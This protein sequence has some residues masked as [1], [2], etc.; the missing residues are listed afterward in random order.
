MSRFGESPGSGGTEINGA[1]TLFLG[2]VSEVVT[3]LDLAGIKHCILPSRGTHATHILGRYF[4][5]GT[6]PREQIVHGENCQPHLVS[7]L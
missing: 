4:I 5:E 7:S 6:W 3:L 1:L 2:I